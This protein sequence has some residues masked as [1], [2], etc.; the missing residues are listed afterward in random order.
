MVALGEALQFTAAAHGADGNLIPEVSFTW[1]SSDERIAAVTVSGL[2][3]AAGNG[4]AT[5]IASAGGVSGTASV[6]VAQEVTAVI[7]APASLSLTALEETAQATANA[8]DA[9]GHAVT[10]KA[11]TWQSSDEGVATVSTSGLVT[12]VANGAAVVTATTDGVSGNA[13]VT[14]SQEVAAV[15]VTPAATTITALGETV[16]LAAM[17]QDGNGNAVAGK[18]FTWASSDVD[19]ATVSNSGMVTAVASGA[20]VVTAATGGMSGNA[21]V[22]VAQQVAA[23]TVT[24]ATVRLAALGETV[25]LTANAQDANGNAVTAKIFTWVSSD[26]RV[27]TVNTSGLVTAVASGAAVV[28]ATT[29]GVSGNANVTVAQEIAAVTVTPGSATITALGETVQLVAAAVD[30]NGHEIAEAEFIWVSSDE[31]VATVSTSGLV[32]G[33]HRCYRRCEWERRRD[34]RAG[35]RGGHGDA[36]DGD[37]HGAGRDRP[38]RRQRPRRQRQCRGR[39]DL[40]G[41]HRCYRRC[42]WERRRDG[43]AG[44]R[45]G[46]GDAGDGDDH[47]AG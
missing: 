17:A 31:S 19:I 29:D 32:G 14:V 39:Q 15:T 4:A 20:A 5:V 10:G 41:R 30:P 21:Q 1:A 24:P 12:A 11:F 36:G 22:M 28:T 3:T 9:N 34:G 43:R 27:A 13:D 26:E 47:G 18:T 2:V 46:H 8:H 45:G 16:Q 35:G 23:V 44:G 33:R 7:V 37:D 25:Q 40:G 42:E 38:A 6:T